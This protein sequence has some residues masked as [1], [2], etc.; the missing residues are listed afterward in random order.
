MG[1]RQTERAERV[2]ERLGVRLGADG[3]AGV[4]VGR[5]VVYS[6]LPG[7]IE[8]AEGRG[9]LGDEWTTDLSG[10]DGVAY[11][12]PTFGVTVHVFD[13]GVVA[14]ADASDRDV[15]AAAITATVTELAATPVE[16]STELDLREIS[17]TAP[18]GQEWETARLDAVVAGESGGADDGESPARDRAPAAD[19]DGES[20]AGVTPSPCAGCGRVPDGWER[21]CPR[22][23]EDLEPDVCDDCGESLGD[24]MLYC[25][26]CGAET[27][28]PP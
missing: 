4:D 13:A 24:W 23:G 7:R 1:E 26:G 20:T 15:A 12:V 9:S 10:T 11:D 14:C 5:R 16:P 18:P 28:G 21:H 27:A 3:L 2:L 8:P 25:P 17:L 19:G 22:C 6:T